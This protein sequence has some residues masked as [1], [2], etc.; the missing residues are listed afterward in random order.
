MDAVGGVG[1]GAA[2]E[3]YED[4][5]QRPSPSALLEES[6]PQLGEGESGALGA[7]CSGRCPDPTGIGWLSPSSQDDTSDRGQGLLS[8][9]LC[10]PPSLALG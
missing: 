4:R 6:L 7:P 1:R 9:G 3:N 5:R 8:L 2:F 10:I